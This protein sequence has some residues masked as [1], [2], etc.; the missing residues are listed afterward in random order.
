MYSIFHIV[1]FDKFITLQSKFYSCI[2]DKEHSSMIKNWESGSPQVM[3]SSG[4]SK[5][6]WLNLRLT[7]GL[8]KY[9]KI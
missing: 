6:S 2:L 3:Q 5:A 1:I 7:F 8:V 9:D 4:K